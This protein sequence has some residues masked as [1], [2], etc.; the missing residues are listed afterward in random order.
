M[1]TALRHLFLLLLVVTLFNSGYGQTPTPTQSP[2]LDPSGYIDMMDLF[3][4][5]ANW[6]AATGP[7]YGDLDGNGTCDPEDL[8]TLLGGWHTQVTVLTEQAIVI[9]DHPDLDFVSATTDEI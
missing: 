3:V 8:L 4:I 5:S 1:K 9:D 2:D 7:Q 6:K